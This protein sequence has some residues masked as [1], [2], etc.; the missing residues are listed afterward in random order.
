MKLRLD[1][2]RKFDV[3]F[4]NGVTCAI[5]NL[6]GKFP[7][8]SDIF[9]ILVIGVNRTLTQS[10]TIY[11]RHGSRPHDLLGDDSTSLRTASS[12]ILTNL[13]RGSA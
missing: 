11:L 7:S 12:D 3:F 13:D 9:I 6:F 5:L 8:D 4:N 10:L 1:T 2:G